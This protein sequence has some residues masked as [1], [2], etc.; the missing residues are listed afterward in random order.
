[1][2][3]VPVAG[4]IQGDAHVAI[5]REHFS[6]R[7]DSG[8]FINI[9]KRSVCVDNLFDMLEFEET[10]CLFVGYLIDGID[11]QDLFFPFIRFLHPA[12]NDTGFHRGIVEEIGA[13]T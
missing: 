13:K 6:D 5:V 2:P 10:L 3:V 1:M 8:K 9:L 11:E 7:N 12:D 4:D